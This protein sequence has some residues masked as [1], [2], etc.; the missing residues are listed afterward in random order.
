MKGHAAGQEL[1][2][3]HQVST[4]RAKADMHRYKLRI[5]HVSEDELFILLVLL[6]V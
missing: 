6:G 2:A 4:E 1:I 3:K 5:T